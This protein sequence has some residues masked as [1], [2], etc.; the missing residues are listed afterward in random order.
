MHN[1][2]PDLTVSFETVGFLCVFLF[3]DFFLWIL[4]IHCD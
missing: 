2:Q 4:D 1:K 3:E